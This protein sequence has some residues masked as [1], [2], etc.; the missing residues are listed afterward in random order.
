MTIKNTDILIIGA[1]AY[2]LSAAWWMAQRRNDSRILVLDAQDFAA[3]GTGRNLASMRMQWGLEFNI[4][5][6]QESIAFFEETEEHLD[7]P[8]GIDLKQEGYLLLAHDERMLQNLRDSRHVHEQ[9]DVPS[10]IL[11]PEECLKIVPTLNPDGILGGSFC[12]KDGT[13]S[14]FLW[15]DALLRACRRAGVYV[16]FDTRVLSIVPQGDGFQ[17]QTVVGSVHAD[18]VLICT[19]WQAPELLQ[20][21]GVDLPISGMP[22]EALVTEPWERVV[23]PVVISFK[24]DI[25]VSQLARGSI[26]AYTTRERP[27]DEDFSSTPEYLPYCARKFVDLLPTL[28]H[29]NVLRTWAG[30]ISQTP[31][32]Q[33][34]LGETEVPNVFVA[35]S[36]YKGFMTSPAVGRIM[37]EIVFDGH[38]DHPAVAPLHPKRFATGDLV[39]E[40]L[41][42]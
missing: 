23:G 30:M 31:D 38:S 22:K 27:Q 8:G 34:V 2:G 16:N 6:S 15:L 42:V 40:P 19:D 37:A 14:P 41:T 12:P 20:P 35:V 4:R 29:L 9:F 24:T 10:E 26:L 33:A 7:Y 17:V 28:S 18:K 21:L 25:A 36:A 1:G 32:M 5:L 3:G 39:P 11:S 13:A